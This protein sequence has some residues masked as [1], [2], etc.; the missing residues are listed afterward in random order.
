MPINELRSIAMFVKTVELGSL[1]QA[2][3]AQ[4]TT[5]QAA[6]QALSVLEKHLNLRLFTRTA[7]GMSLTDEGQE[8]LRAARP[9]LM[10]L[11]HAVHIARRARNEVIGP[12]RIVASRAV[13]APVLWPVLD[14]FCEEHLQVQP[15][16]RL[17]EQTDQWGAEDTFDVRF[18]ADSQPSGEV[19]AH[20]L[21]PVQQLICAA[22]AYL[23]QHG[24]PEN[25]DSL[26]RHRCL[27]VCI[28]DN[29]DVLAWRVNVD[30]QVIE[31]PV[32]PSLCINDDK[33]RLNLLLSGHF[34]GMLPGVTAAA[35]VRAGR[36]VPLLT[37]HLTAETSAFLYHGNTEAQSICVK[38]FI[39]LARERLT[40][41]SSY[42]LSPSELSRATPG[43]AIRSD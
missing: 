31:H 28:S 8:F 3:A 32:A 21:F 27:G 16:V 29:R 43:W 34:V 15:S 25:L 36:L 13:L 19:T 30:G 35:H 6:S 7:R 41:S 42:V 20:R 40:D 26:A 14:E 24:V 38:A 11:Q 33:L 18:A 10:G 39:A 9:S 37:R 17:Y 5:P 1:R 4:G 2:A 23:A 12:L 22:P